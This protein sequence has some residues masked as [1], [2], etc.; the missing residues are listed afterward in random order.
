MFVKN[1]LFPFQFFRSFAAIQRFEIYLLWKRFSIYAV[2]K[3]IE[4]VDMKWKVTKCEIYA[5]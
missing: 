2:H 5:Q 4:V 1:F 3:A